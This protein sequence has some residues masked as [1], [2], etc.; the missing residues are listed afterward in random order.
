MRWSCCLRIT[1]AYAGK[2]HEPLFRRR[3]FWDHP[4]VC[5]EKSHFRC[6]AASCE[7][8]PPRMRG[9][10]PI[11]ISMFCRFGITPAYAGKRGRSQ[12]NMGRCEDHPRVCGEKAATFRA[13]WVPRGSPPR[14]RG[15]D[16]GC[17][18]HH[19]KHRITPAYAR[20][21]AAASFHPGT[22][23]DH[24]RVC[25]EKLDALVMAVFFA[26]SPPRMR[27]KVSR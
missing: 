5:G 23:Q 3:A 15:K 25:G 18:V 4:R 14:M 22:I 8:S 20:K 27:G 13:V 24:P 26:G 1:P 19:E 16:A 2:R 21:R 10:E 9:K 11:C 7:G 17:L 6:A 12:A